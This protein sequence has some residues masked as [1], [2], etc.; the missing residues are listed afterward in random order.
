MSTPGQPKA[1]RLELALAVSALVACTWFFACIVNFARD[2]AADDAFISYTYGR[3]LS[4]GHGLRYNASD[5][6]PTAGASSTLH[7]LYIAA[8]LKLGL[9]PLMA[10]RMLGIACLL[11]IAIVFG[12]T[13]ARLARATPAGGV[14]AGITV[15]FLFSL[16]SETE[17]H[18]ASGMET[19]LFTATHAFCAAWAA[20]AV[21]D[22]RERLPFA[23]LAG[24]AVALA[25]LLLARP[26]GGLLGAGYLAAVVAARTSRGGAMAQLKS[27]RGVVIVFALGVAALLVWRQL[28]FGRVFAN[29]YYV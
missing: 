3:N 11:A 8:A 13:G 5:A 7:V 12:L 24:G 27:L 18:L 14:L 10:T 20:C 6:A 26:E 1:S 23:S 16:L 22:E 21:F 29:P 17:V 9:D 25:L 19:L 15:V 2:A 4:Q 28:Y